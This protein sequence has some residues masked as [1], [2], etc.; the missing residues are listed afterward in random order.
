MDM[1]HPVLEPSLPPGPQPPSMGRIVLF[2]WRGPMGWNTCPAIITR[3]IDRD[4]LVINLHAFYD[5]GEL[6][7]LKE[8]EDRIPHS[9]DPMF[10]GGVRWSWPPRV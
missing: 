2:H 10:N 3:V 4:K 7:H 5:A 8:K 9:E 1:K 6:V